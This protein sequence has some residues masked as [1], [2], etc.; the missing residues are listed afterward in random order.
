VDN[1]RRHNVV[2]KQLLESSVAERRE[3]EEAQASGQA[4]ESPV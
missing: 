4:L 2:L 3:E 1:M